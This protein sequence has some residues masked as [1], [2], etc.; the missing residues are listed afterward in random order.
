MY[1]L[2]LSVSLKV[3][4]I[5]TYIFGKIKIYTKKIRI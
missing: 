2:K 1:S 5:V 3:K 4:Y